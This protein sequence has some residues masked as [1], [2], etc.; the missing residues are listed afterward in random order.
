MQMEATAHA[1]ESYL[2]GLRDYQE[3]AVKSVLRTW[4]N[5]VN[6]T[7]VVAATGAGKTQLFLSIAMYVLDQDARNRV[8]IIAHRKELIEQ[9]QERIRMMRPDWLMATFTPRVGT[10]MAALNQ[11]DRQ[12]TIATVQSLSEGRVDALLANGPITHL[13]ID[14][15]HHAVAGT[16]VRVYEQLKAANPDLKHLG[17]TA[18]P[19]R[20]DGEGLIKM[21]QHTAAKI[22]IGDLVRK[23][24]LVAPRWL[25]L[26]TSLSMQGVQ[27]T[28]KDFNEVQVA[29]I[30]DSDLAHAYFLKAWHDYAKG[31]RTIAFTASVDGAERL[32]NAFNEAGVPAACVSGKTP[33]DERERILAAY[34][35]KEITVLTNCDVLTEGF[36]APGTSC[37]MM[38][39]PT[40]SSSAYVQRMGRGLRPANGI[41][42]P[43]EDCLILDFLPIDRRDALV[44]AGD[45]LGVPKDQL[46]PV[47]TLLKEPG[48]DGAAQLGFT[49]D[50]EQIHFSD[51]ALVI[52]AEVINYLDET[53]LRWNR[54]DAEGGGYWLVLG[55]GQCHDG[56]HRIIAVPPSPRDRTTFDMFGLVRNEGDYTWQVKPLLNDASFCDVEKLAQRIVDRYAS[57]IFTKK[58]ARWLKDLASENQLKFVRSL[59]RKCGE[60]VPPHVTKGQASALIDFY[61]CKIALGK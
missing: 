31:R 17:V 16:Y 26:E 39:R 7:L 48:E 4:N 57:D 23:H 55:L 27:A 33:K 2:Q 24:Y 37:I 44:L 19:M 51:D 21:Y 34:K 11:N 46:K 38:C 15:A 49:F 9:P 52:I 59:A 14:E 43:G 54:Y 29:K 50:G 1:L 41:A 30:F 40:K 6:D 47:E 25:A 8:L 45:V 32:A 60:K 56:K 53:P 58:N 22:T 18:T 20:G 3:D 28:K 36:D 61:Q 42:E 35:N 12:L 5:G 13:I 10:I